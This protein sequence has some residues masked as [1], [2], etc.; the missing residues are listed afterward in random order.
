VSGKPKEGVVYTDI[1]VVYMGIQSKNNIIQ[2][3]KYGK[4]GKNAENT[5]SE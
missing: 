4:A 2:V 3:Q 5:K 1:P